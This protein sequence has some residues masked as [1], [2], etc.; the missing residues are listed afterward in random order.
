MKAVLDSIGTYV[1][2]YGFGSLGSNIFLDTLPG[3]PYACIGIFH[4][5]GIRIEGNPLRRIDFQLRVRNPDHALADTIASSLYTLFDNKWCS[6][7]PSFRGNFQC[8]SEVNE[9][10]VDENS[11]ALYTFIVEYKTVLV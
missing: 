11:H 3:T 5:G 8:L 9:K 2:S 4:Y 1:A 7:A 10:T 6:L